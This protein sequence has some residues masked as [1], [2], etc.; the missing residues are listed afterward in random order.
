MSENVKVHFYL[1]LVA[2]IYGANYT[3]AKEVLDGGYLHPFTF[4]LCRVF[5]SLILFSLYHIAFI[6]EKVDRQD[7]G[8]IILCSITGVA[9]NQL[10][11]LSGLAL[12]TPIN[13]SLIMTTSPILVLIVSALVLG[14]KITS[15]KIVGILIG[16]IGTIII[17]AY[18][19]SIS[20]N[21]G[22]Y[23]GDLF[24]FL[25]ASA[26]GIYLVLVKRLIRKYHP[27]TVIRWVF[28]VGILWV[29]PFGAGGLVDVDWS[30]FSLGIWLS[31]FYV[32]IFT[33][34]FAYLLNSLALTT[35]NPS[36]VSIYIYLQ[37]LIASFIALVFAKDELS[38]IKIL[39]GIMIFIGVYLV[40]F[41][42]GQVFKSKLKNQ[43]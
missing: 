11:F 22:G 29:I 42:V 1:F 20:F 9:M 18:G 27:I 10:F 30:S 38:W 17:I 28:T 33:T 3:I 31:F 35:V 41:P 13:A 7:F 40:S 26:Y 16:A 15:T 34:F 21:R 12:T 14:E 25:N 5:A 32:L 39:A 37:P 36:V 24:I 6:K 4:V 19:H 23:L 43:Y 2:L 8:W